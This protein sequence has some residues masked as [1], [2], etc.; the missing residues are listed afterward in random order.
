MLAPLSCY[1]DGINNERQ[2]VLRKRNY[3]VA[4]KGLNV[5][6]MIITTEA[7]KV[8][9]QDQFDVSQGPNLKMQLKRAFQRPV[10][11]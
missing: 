7:S 3:V 8:L 2:I 1:V 10:F 11:Y 4:L 6:R 5:L 9:P